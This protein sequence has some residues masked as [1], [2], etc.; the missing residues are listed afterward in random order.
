MSISK[1]ALVVGI[2]GMDGESAAHF[3]LS[4]GYTVIGTYRKNSHIDLGDLATKYSN[5]ISFEYCEI[6]DFNSVRSCIENTLK[7]HGHIDEVYLIAAQSHVGYSFN[8]P[9]K[10][11]ITNGMSA[12]NFLENLRLVS[13]KTKLYFCATSELLGGDPLRCP[14]NEESEY[15]C[16]SPYS[17]G[18]EL[19][20]R[21]IKYYVQTYGMFACYGILFNH[22]NCSREKSFFIRKVTNGAARIALGLQNEIKLGNLNFWRDEHW[23]DL[24]VEMMWKMLQNDKPETYV[25]C[26]GNGHYGEEFLFES[27]NYFN[28]DW[29][30]YVKIDNSLF[31]P[32]EVVKL[33]GDPSKAIKEL[34]WR[35]NRISFKDHINLMC[36]YD[37]DLELNKNPVRPDVFK[38]FP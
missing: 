32:N 6:S 14:F 22:S 31:R 20:T 27:F 24:G 36:E 33:V 34:G 12:Y 19:G 21:W 5:R 9:E 26:N 8:E 15:E 38:L 16:R 25:I 23:S 17:I 35:P 28:L 18:K 1:V 3:L 30:K 13:I 4:K 7:Q 10:T 11:V 2:T 29:K 37:Y